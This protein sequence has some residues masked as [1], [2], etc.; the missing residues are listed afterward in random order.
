VIVV[1]DSTVLIGLAKLGKLTLLKEIFLKVSV[2]EEVF[3]EVVERGQGKSGSRLIKESR[4]I[5]IQTVKDKTLVSF[6]MGSLERGEA[7]VLAL[8][9]ELRADLILVDEEKAR[10]SALIAGFNVM[11]LLGLLVL[12][13]NLDLIDEIKPLIDELLAKKFRISDKVIEEALKKAGEQPKL[14]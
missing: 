1:A 9:G 6:L 7:E 12:A 10:K 5:E 13:K 14:G 3:K 8:A 2:P 11:G 4:W